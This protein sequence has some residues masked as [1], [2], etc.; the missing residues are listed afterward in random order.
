[1]TISAE[2]EQEIF[3]L[4]EDLIRC[5]DNATPDG[6]GCSLCHFHYKKIKYIVDVNKGFTDKSRD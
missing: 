3:E 6:R 2:A 1:M 5:N 4:L